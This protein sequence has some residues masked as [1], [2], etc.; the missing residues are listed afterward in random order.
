MAQPTAA[1]V[2]RA[3]TEYSSLTRAA[4]NAWFFKTGPG[5]YGEGDVFVGVTMPNIRKVARAYTNLSLVETE[6]LLASKVHEHRMTG[7]IVLVEKYE[8]GERRTH[9]DIA[10]WYLAHIDRV[11][12]WD[13]VDC[14][15]PQILGKHYLMYGGEKKLYTFTKSRSLWRRRVAIV[16]TFAFIRAGELTHTFAIAELLLKDT[17]DLIHK[18]AGWMLRVAGKM[19]KKALEHFLKKHG[20]DMP[21]T[22]LRYAIERFPERERKKWLTTSA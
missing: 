18:A 15:A 19:D 11:N 13:L 22:M 12:N 5:E 16:A 3:L 8:R 14:S 10:K 17:H 9:R 4:T 20:T 21:R 6:K 1:A 7:L 2:K